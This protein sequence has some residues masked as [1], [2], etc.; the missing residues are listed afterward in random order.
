MSLLPYLHRAAAREDLSPTDAELAMS[1][2]LSGQ[3]ST[4]LIAAFLVALGMKGETSN[5]LLGFARAMR[6][7]STPVQVPLDGKPLLD[8]C[9]TGGQ[10]GP[11]TFNISTVAAFVVAGAG[12]RVAKHG[13]RSITT[14]CGSA[15]I[16]ES[17]G[18]DIAAGPAHAARAIQEVGIGFLFAPLLHP[19]M[20]FAQPAR[21][22]LKMRTAL[23]LLGPLTNPAGAT[24]QLI[25]AASPEAARLIA[26]ALAG[27]GIHRAFVVHGA[28]GLDEVTTTGPTLA[29]E[30]RGA[31][32][33][34]LTLHPAD[35]GVPTAPAEALLGG[36]RAQNTRIA[37]SI[38][39]CEPGPQRDIVVVNAA[40]ALVAA[41]AAPNFR[42]AAQLAAYSIDSGRA[43]DKLTQLTLLH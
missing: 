7:H 39:A 9:G 34:P 30:I 16:M 43:A 17:L 25:G 35:F 11:A 23:N 36:D 18:V 21:A 13:N 32:V 28:D 33:T 38:L 4:P 15:D 41:G 27:L 42:E 24:S 29:Y 3:A 1:A 10:A 31:S 8:T 5:E 20:K 22:E 40:T 14:Q 37:R 12:I 19:A 26:H 2:I 6:A